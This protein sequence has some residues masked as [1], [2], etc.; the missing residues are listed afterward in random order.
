VSVGRTQQPLISPGGGLQVAGRPLSIRGAYSAPYR[1]FLQGGQAAGTLLM[2]RYTGTGVCVVT[3][4]YFGSVVVG[5][6]ISVAQSLFFT[7]DRYTSWTANDT[8]TGATGTY[9]TSKRNTYPTAQV[10]TLQAAQ[11]VPLTNGTSTFAGSILW[12]EFVILANAVGTSMAHQRIFDSASND[13]HPLMFAQNEGFRLAG[14]AVA[15][16]GSPIIIDGHIHWFE[17]TTW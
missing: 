2:F 10:S 1:I 4:I 7:V 3:D 5:G 9:L 15:G 11:G 12:F 8:G 6:G 14:P 17:A 13:G 16:T